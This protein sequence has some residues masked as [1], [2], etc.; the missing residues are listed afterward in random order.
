MME[1]FTLLDT[2]KDLIE[3][4]KS[5][6]FSDK[7]VVQRQQLLDIIRE[8]YLKLPDELKTAKWI[9]EE[10]DRIIQ[11]AHEE[12]DNIMKEAEDKIIER[13]DDHEITKRAYEKQTEI[14]AEAN[15]RNREMK[16]GTN[17]YV[18]GILENAE[19]DLTRLNDTIA[20]VEKNIQSALETLKNNR[21]ELK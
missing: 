15:N 1:I 11:E 3:N 9:K 14:I 12:A 5:I 19:T 16:D 20:E 7:A 2:L 17:K 21:N 8:I 4:S 10:R 13:I 6:P 18:D